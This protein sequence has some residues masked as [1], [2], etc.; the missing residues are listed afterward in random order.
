MQAHA[1]IGANWGDEGKGLLTDFLARQVHDKTVINVRMNGGAQAGHTVVTPDRRHVF[2]HFGSA[3]FVPHVTTYLGSQFIVNPILFMRERAELGPKHRGYV[4]VHPDAVVTTPY[5][6]LANQAIEGFRNNTRHGSCGV[7]I[8]ETLNR[9]KDDRHRITVRDLVGNRTNSQLSLEF[10]AKSKRISREWLPERLQQLGVYGDA[11]NIA[12]QMSRVKEM[13][14]DF[15]ECCIDFRRNI[16]AVLTEEEFVKAHKTYPLFFL[17]EGAQGL[18]LHQRHEDFPH[19]TPSNT[20]IEN[21][22]PMLRAAGLDEL[23]ITYVTRAYMTRHGAG[24]LY[25]EMPRERVVGH[26]AVD[27]TN[28]EHTY[29]EVLRYAPLDDVHIEAMNQR[30]LSDCYSI[31]VDVRAGYAMTCLDHIQPHLF[32]INAVR[33]RLGLPLRYTSN[34]PTAQDVTAL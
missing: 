7:G 27:N 4:I 26:N 31:P 13:W 24:P 21:C 18:A 25:G 20:G 15:I 6:M 5:D 12:V 10:L 19:V 34:G 11:Y 14:Q 3:S 29:Q 28:V 30:C 33:D 23:S 1:V 9:S 16:S 2:H 32:D 22:L 17:F 8:F